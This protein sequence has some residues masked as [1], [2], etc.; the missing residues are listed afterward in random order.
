[1]RILVTDGMDRKALAALR[2]QGHAVTER[3]YEPDQLGKALRDFDTVVIR[4][5]TRVQAEQLEEARGGRLK[6]IIRGG[7]G[8]DNIDVAC[9]EALGYTVRNTPTASS[10]S[11]AELALGHMLSCARFLSVAGCTMRAGRWEKNAYEGVELR[12]KTLGIIGFGRIGR[13]LAAMADAL[14][15]KVMA[16]DV[17]PAPSGKE[18]PCVPYVELA[19]LLAG[20]DFISLHTPA[21]EGAP[22]IT[23]Q[24]L[25]QMK[26]GAILINTSRGSSI[27][28]DA[29]LD[30]L[31]SGKLRGAGLDVYAD[32]KNRNQALINHP[33]V[34]C[35]P[36]IGG[37]TAEAQERIG[38]EIV[39]I[40]GNFVK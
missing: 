35:T 33:H 8:V 7:V 13:R 24:T 36:H 19:E 2:A 9:A 21:A 34:S 29:L 11:V 1:M 37:S 32:E 23:A 6:L 31:N 3:F 10:E 25:A 27:D 26:D 20:A 39:Q 16:Y 28:E 17:A 30:A 18:S 40:I 4:S 5:R 14:G 12:G 22:L 15:M 38:Q